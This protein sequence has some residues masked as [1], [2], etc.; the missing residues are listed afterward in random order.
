MT[1][2]SLSPVVG[3]N[4][5]RAARSPPERRRFPRLAVSR[6][7]FR[8]KPLGKLFAL[9]DVS[10]TGFCL[11]VSE[12]NDLNAF[13]VG[14]EFQGELGFR[15]DRFQVK[16]RVRHLE[17]GFVGAELIDIAPDARARLELGLDPA[18]LGGEMRLI[19][20]NDLYQLWWHAMNGADWNVELAAGG[21][22]QAFL[23][24][25]HGT[26]IRWSAERDTLDTGTIG[27]MLPVDPDFGAVRMETWTLSADEALDPHKMRIA[28]QLLSGCKEKPE[29]RDFC[30][31]VIHS[32]MP[33]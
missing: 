29:F 33:S 20:G 22:V 7:A 31:R 14:S 32:R 25:L 15:G 18:R 12:D 30:S 9:A 23:L 21:Q 17:R 2:N 16:A 27:H 13:P 24:R 8:L 11:R 28:I 3:S 10:L 6:E 19:P 4:E 5:V 26:F 1:Q